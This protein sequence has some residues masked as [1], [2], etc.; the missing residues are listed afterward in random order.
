[1]SIFNAFIPLPKYEKKFVTFGEEILREAE[2]NLKN[3][4]D[5]GKMTN[6]IRILLANRNIL[7]ENEIKDE[8]TTMIMAVCL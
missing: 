4:Y 1:M 7:T 6:F 5:D 8:V 3:I 2:E